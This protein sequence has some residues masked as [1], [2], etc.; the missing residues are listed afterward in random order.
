MLS[1]VLGFNREYER[2]TREDRDAEPNSR[3]FPHE[4]S[5]CLVTPYYD[6]DLYNFIGGRPLPT[7]TVRHVLRQAAAGLSYLHSMGVIHRDFKSSNIFLGRDG[8]VVIAD[9]GQAVHHTPDDARPLTP[10]QCSKWYRAPELL[11]GSTSYDA[12]VD[13]WALGVVLVEMSTGRPPFMQEGDILQ[14]GAILQ[15][16][17][18]PSKSNWPGAL[19]LPDYRKVRF[20]PTSAQSIDTLLPDA[21]PALKDLADKM[22]QA[23]PTRRI[24][25]QEVLRHPFMT[26]GPAFF[27]AD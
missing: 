2:F 17:G 20:N 12:K 27:S 23:D 25:V 21:D 8:H 14:L 7:P 9:L 19:R 5:V 4:T 22:L 26:G 6:H 1:K 3:L 16:S 11:F 24:G 10:Q 15:Y 18:T 13:V